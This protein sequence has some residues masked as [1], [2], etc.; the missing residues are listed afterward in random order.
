MKALLKLLTEATGPTGK[1]NS[2]REVVRS[3]VEP[4]ADEISVDVMGNLIVQK[5]QKA[6]NGL[7]IML[8]AH[9]DEIGVIVT[10]VDENGFVRFASVGGVRASSC[11]STRVK[12]TNG[13]I[14]VI[15]MEPTSSVTE[16][17][18]LHKMFIDVGASC[19]GDCPVKVGDFATF[20]Q[21]FVDLGNRVIAKAM[22]DRAGAAVLVKL[23]EN[24]K[25]TPHEL[26][27]VFSTQE[28][29]G[30]RGAK[31][32]AYKIDPDLGIALDVTLTG[33]APKAATME[34]SLG[35]GPA[36][37]IKD[38]GMIAS[39]ALV[40]V[41]CAAAQENNIPYQLEVLTGGTTD[42]A[43]I[44]LNNDG[45]A[46]GCV[47]IPCRYVHTPSEMV[48]IRDVENSVQLLYRVL[49]KPIVF[50]E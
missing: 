43:A 45:V 5:G 38:S 9:I 10:H 7:R 42:A 19:V 21:P 46:A 23:L 40:Q 12:F 4:Y 17:Q 24:I 33:D 47:S 25:E 14:G 39:P 11:Y 49:T 37:K 15:G 30:L 26:Y 34:V 16:V 18:P 29:V 28:E 20:L 35:K 3:L 41:L 44:Q 32:A 31:T 48:D 27:F 6:N 50:E 22:D 13:T 1:E 8:S 2:V 36:I